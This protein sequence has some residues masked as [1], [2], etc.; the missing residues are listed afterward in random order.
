MAECKECGKW[1]YG[2]TKK[3]ACD[4]EPIETFDPN[5]EPSTPFATYVPS[6]TTKARFSTHRTLGHAKNAIKGN[7]GILYQWVQGVWVE[8][9][10]MTK[11]EIKNQVCCYCGEPARDYKHPDGSHYLHS[12]WSKDGDLKVEYYDR[13]CERNHDVQH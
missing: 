6:R 8:M 3:C 5:K 12:R 10:R 13:T 11:E 7:E 1:S 2:S 9:F 4:A